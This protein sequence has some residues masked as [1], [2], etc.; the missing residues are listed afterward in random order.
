MKETKSKTMRACLKPKV[1]NIVLI[2]QYRNGH[3]FNK[4]QELVSE[5]LTKN[6]QE[7]QNTLRDMNGTL[8]IMNG[9][10]VWQRLSQKILEV[11][12]WDTI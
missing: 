7:Y 1:D 2:K 5:R 10:N 6:L 3:R 12:L 8:R 4:S 9:R 11:Q